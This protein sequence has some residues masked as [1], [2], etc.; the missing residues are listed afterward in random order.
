MSAETRANGGLY[1]KI[2]SIGDFVHRR[3]PTPFVEAWNHWL[4]RS[5]AASRDTLGD[6]WHDAYLT[7]PLW[8]FALDP[9]VAGTD[10]WLGVL[11]SSV[12]EVR[13]CYPMTVALS[14]PAGMR[15]G[16]LVNDLVFVFEALEKLVLQL[17]DGTCT[18]DAATVSL[19]QLARALPQ[20]TA[21]DAVWS[22][23]DGERL[24]LDAHYPSIAAMATHLGSNLDD[25]AEAEPLLSAWWHAGWG[26]T[27]PASLV[28]VGLPSPEIFVC[29]LDG[30]W[31]DRG[32][33]PAIDL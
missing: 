15:L 25:R 28:V 18:P 29:F 13:R 2:P 21:L 8:R 17:I 4:E 33:A 14:L 12:D 3:L 9:G 26:A 1:G 22:R 20:L 27:P 19:D 16:G 32:W 10:G 30:A 7:S 6:R 5:L 31:Q 11:A 24:R 23:G